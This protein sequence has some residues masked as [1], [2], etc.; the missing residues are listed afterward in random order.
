M[1]GESTR[2]RT[3][4]TATD[5]KSKDSSSSQEPSPKKPPAYGKQDYWEQ[6]Y[7]QNLN[8]ESDSKQKALPET[9]HSWYFSYEELSPIL[10]PIILGDIADD[11]SDNDNNEFVQEDE[12]EQEESPNHKNTTEVG[13]EDG[14]NDSDE[15]GDQDEHIEENG[16]A[17]EED[18]DE[19][20]V[21][22]EEIEDDDSG[23]QAARR[24]GLAKDGAI[25]VLE[26]GCGDVPLGRDLA[27][28]IASLESAIG[29][30]ASNILKQVVCIDYAKSVIDIMKKEQEK[31]S[32]DS[33][34]VLYEVGDARKL[35]Y[36]DSSFELILEK[37]TMDAML[38]DTT[39]GAE[40]CRLIVAECAR[41][42]TVGGE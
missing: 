24:M 15:N 38:S 22:F 13:K 7:N 17:E 37:G 5:S 1:K 4:E 16:D 41:L 19:D 31:E 8:D 20:F 25:S 9:F 27:R 40:N 36:P 18:E 21:E 3:R 30:A 34:S 23:D 11:E 35:V 6:R 26:V 10:L 33:V 39:E 12:A 28:G 42:L 29:V 32:S 14:E 2:K